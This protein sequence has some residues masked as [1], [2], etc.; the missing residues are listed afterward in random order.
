MP[1]Q[2]GS[3]RWGEVVKPSN[4]KG[5]Y[6]LV[7]V[8]SD[9]HEV[10]AIVL[11]PYG[12]QGSPL[13]GGQA[14]MIPIDGDEG[15]MVAI[16]MPP[17]AKRTDEQKEGEVSYP[18]HDT[19]NFIKHDADGNTTIQTKGGAIIKEWKDGTIG[20]KPGAGQKVALGDVKPDGMARVMTE[21]GPS[22]I[23][24]AKVS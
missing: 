21:A 16:I 10:T 15:K 13:K 24:W 22:D 12:V 5:P 17:P 23:V 11:E 9:G 7:R 19:G 2:D 20:V 3:F 14:L 8:Q 6:K 18:N 4:D 1:G